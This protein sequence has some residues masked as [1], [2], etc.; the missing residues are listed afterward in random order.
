MAEA[1]PT[2]ILLRAATKVSLNERFTKLMHSRP[3]TVIEARIAIHGTV[4]KS[5]GRLAHQLQLEKNRVTQNWNKISI[6]DR[7]GAPRGK[8]RGRGISR[9][10][11]SAVLS[12]LGHGGATL[13]TNGNGLVSTTKSKTRRGFVRNAFKN[14]R[15]NNRGK[16][17]G[18]LKRD[19][20]RNR[21]KKVDKTSLDAQIESYMSKTKSSMDAELDVYNASRSNV[22]IPK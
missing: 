3:P 7:L 4:R 11:R 15:N 22:I 21:Q 13:Q 17:R 2:K 6:K 5:N 19:T 10:A 9:G 12:R 14:K 18:G 16:G 20:Q 8:T 1:K